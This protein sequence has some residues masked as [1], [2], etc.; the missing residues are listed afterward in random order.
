[1]ILNVMAPLSAQ[2]G[3]QWYPSTARNAALP[4]ER[5]MA[6]IASRSD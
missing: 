1:V 4:Y 2:D 5:D 3:R 6:R